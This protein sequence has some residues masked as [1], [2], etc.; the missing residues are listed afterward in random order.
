MDDFDITEYYPI[1][2]HSV[3]ELAKA[4]HTEELISV[5]QPPRLFIAKQPQTNGYKFRLLCETYLQSNKDLNATIRIENLSPEHFT[6]FQHVLV[7][8]SLANVIA[9]RSHPYLLKSTSSKLFRP[10]GS[11]EDLKI[12]YKI[13]S[14]QNE[15][16]IDSMSIFKIPVHMIMGQLEL[17]YYKLTQIK[18]EPLKKSLIDYIRD[19]IESFDLESVLIKFQLVGYNLDNDTEKFTY[20]SAPV[21]SEKIT[22]DM[23]K[24]DEKSDKK[25]PLEVIYSSK[26]VASARG[27]EELIVITKP[28]DFKNRD[29]KVEFLKYN[30]SKVEWSI[31]ID[32][33]SVF[34][35]CA[36]V[37]KTPRYEFDASKLPKNKR[38]HPLRLFLR[39]IDRDR[40]E[41]SNEWPICYQLQD[42]TLLDHYSSQHVNIFDNFVKKIPVENEVPTEKSEI[43]DNSKKITPEKPKGAPEVIESDHTIVKN[44][45]DRK[46]K[47]EALMER[48]S[49]SLFEVAQKRSLHKLFKTQR[50]L[51]S[52]TGNNPDGN[53]PLHWCILN[54]NF[55]LAEIFVDVALT[56]T[57]YEILNLKNSLNLTPLLLAAHMNE[58]EMCALLIEAAAVRLNE[59][60][61]NGD[62]F[63]HIACAK[64]NLK[65]VKHFANVFRKLNETKFSCLIQTN[66]KGETPLHVAVRMNY[67]L[68]VQELLL[69]YS[70]E[71]YFMDENEKQKRRSEIEMHSKR[72]LETHRR[73]GKNALHTAIAYNF[74]DVTRILMQ[75]FVS[76]FLPIDVVNVNGFTGLQV[77]ILNRN[78]FITRHMLGAYASLNAKSSELAHPQYFFDNFSNFVK[79]QL[80]LSYFIEDCKNVNNESKQN[81]YK[82]DLGDVSVV[83]KTGEEV[84]GYAVFSFNSFSSAAR[85][86]RHFNTS[87]DYARADEILLSLVDTERKLYEKSFVNYLIKLEAEKKF[88]FNRVNE[89]GERFSEKY[90]CVDYATTVE[91]V[92]EN[93]GGFSEQLSNRNAIMGFYKDET[94]ILESKDEQIASKQFE[95]EIIQNNSFIAEFTN[96][97]DTNVRD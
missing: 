9:T 49:A 14:D 87:Y 38:E 65:I 30:K 79:P 23:T 58:S 1:N 40:K 15:I 5:E 25:K 42:Y 67:P 68:I 12:L 2:Q 94:T 60:D 76:N 51:L 10:R 63:L 18:G 64:N 3:F 70:S 61:L 80:D 32:Y 81:T 24:E 16:S 19:Q 54:G 50:Y 21:F 97:Q 92:K 17:N 93:P 45:M 78:F 33:A 52:S 26:I 96:V 34:N 6:S 48:L 74:V 43:S 55:D 20:I 83:E 57:S 66:L 8:V 37:L 75:F 71:N 59:H 86:F 41:I 13:N 69:I 7:E 46:K 31:I 77:A 84:K 85:H 95:S 82:I 62:N 35:N 36:I 39:L 28:I 47:M 27:N 88:K 53:T 11:N 4:P 44:I 89:I 72:V 29:I 91:K 90:A 22:N 73:S 56:I